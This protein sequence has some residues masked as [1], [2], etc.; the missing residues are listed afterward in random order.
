VPPRRATLTSKIIPYI[1][2]SMAGRCPHQSI[3][4]L[5]DGSVLSGNVPGT[6]RAYLALRGGDAASGWAAAG[7]DGGHGAPL[8]AGVVGDGYG[9]RRVWSCASSCVGAPRLPH[10]RP[11]G[12]SRESRSGV[13]FGL[14]LGGGAGG[15]APAAEPGGVAPARAGGGPQC[16]VRQRRGSGQAVRP[17]PGCVYPVGGHRPDRCLPGPKGAGQPFTGPVHRR[18]APGTAPRPCPRATNRPLAARCRAYQPARPARS[19]AGD[20]TESASP[21]LPRQWRQESRSSMPALLPAQASKDPA[22]L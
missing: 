9:S 5:A 6:V 12:L 17:R 7:D 2:R 11:V 3:D 8:R 20:W 15:P 13:R 10:P 21:P 16:T 19:P 4:C 14:R 18:P 1:F 22:T